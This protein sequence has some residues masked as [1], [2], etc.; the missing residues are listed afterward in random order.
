MRRYRLRR[1]ERR[2]PLRWALALMAASAFC[3][4]WVGRMDA[5]PERPPVL[6]NVYR[7][8]ID[9]VVTMD[10]EEYVKG[11]VAAEMPATFHIEALKAQAVAAR[12]LALYLLQQN[13]PLPDH[14]E[15]IISTDFRTH[16]AWR[17]AE[18]AR[19]E[20]G[21]SYYWRWAKISRAVAETRGL[22]MTYG[23]EVIYPAY[24]A[25]S[26]G[27]TED[28][29]NYWTSYMPYL[30]SVDDPY[31]ANDRYRET[32]AV[33]SKV[34]LVEAVA[35][36]AGTDAAAVLAGTAAPAGAGGAGGAGAARAA[37]SGGGIGAGGEAQAP[38]A[39]RL[40]PVQVLSRFPSGR[41][42]RVQVGGVVVT[43]R[44]LREALGLR[45]NWF[46]VEDLGDSVRFIV[47]GYGHGIGMSQY[48]ANAMA[49][50]GFGFDQ[51]LTHYYTGV[52]IVSWYE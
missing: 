21:F 39:L 40:L 35:A 16:Q 44:Q 38:A 25:S 43:G 36:L 7:H 6:L 30:R 52:E 11:V 14:S 13:R 46:E 18:S 20:W 27:R 2:V 8:D 37:G 51:I 33:V 31:S 28:S 9:R 41:V 12:T 19:E 4:W 42:E 3:G 22:I 50:A 10:L 48:G 29:E 45:S 47:R 5:L 34:Q 1:R 17:S 15:A 49:R 24:H 23:G 26:G 32:E